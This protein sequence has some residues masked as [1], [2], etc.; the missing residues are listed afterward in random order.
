VL[1]LAAMQKGPALNFYKKNGFN[2]HS[3]TEIK[4]KQA[5][6]AE[7]PMFIMIKKID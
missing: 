3:T 4:F 5:I 7:K 1:W 2:I 6:K